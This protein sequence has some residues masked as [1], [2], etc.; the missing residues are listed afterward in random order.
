MRWKKVHWQDLMV[1]NFNVR[2][3]YSTFERMDGCD[4]SKE[5]FIVTLKERIAGTNVFWK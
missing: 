3:I 4:Y 5:I 2:K 1:A